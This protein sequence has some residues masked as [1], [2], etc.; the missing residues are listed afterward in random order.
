MKETSNKFPK[1]S[2]FSKKDRFKQSYER[3]LAPL[4][5]S[6]GSV[7]NIGRIECNKSGRYHPGVC[8][9]N[10]GTCFI[11][12]SL[13]HFKRDYPKWN[14]PNRG[15]NEISIVNSAQ[16]RWPGNSSSAGTSRGRN[17]DVTARSETISLAKIYAIRT[18]EEASAPEVIAGTFSLFDVNVYALIDLGLTHPYICTTLASEKY[19]HVV[20]TDC[21]IKVTMI[22][23]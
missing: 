22:F 11:Y 19:L 2:G 10:D 18:R 20:S 6:A 7:W 9:L 3:S 5:A 21:V 23:L 1:P 8:R 16:G 12:G 4:V 17:R 15:K 14:E 13:D